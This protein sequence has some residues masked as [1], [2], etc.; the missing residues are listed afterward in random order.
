[1][2]TNWQTI[3][4]FLEEEIDKSPN[5]DTPPYL[6]HF[7]ILLYQIFMAYRVLSQTLEPPKNRHNR[8]CPWCG[9]EF[10]ARYDF[11]IACTVNHERLW[12]MYPP[13]ISKEMQQKIRA[14]FAKMEAEEKAQP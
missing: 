14:S 2:P 4:D 11:V 3:Q 9:I 7:L 5:E 8:R 10:K 12:R 13:E 6:Y 1:M